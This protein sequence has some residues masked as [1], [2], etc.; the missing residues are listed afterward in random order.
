MPIFHLRAKGE[1]TKTDGETAEAQGRR[2][3]RRVYNSERFHFLQRLATL[4]G[5]GEQPGGTAE[6]AALVGKA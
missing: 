2:S 4:P 3:G 1:Q 6:A 5:M